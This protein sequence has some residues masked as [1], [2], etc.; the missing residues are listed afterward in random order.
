MCK[1]HRRL[2]KISVYENLFDLELYPDDTIVYN[3]SSLSGMDL[4]GQKDPKGLHQYFMS[5]NYHR[6][7][8]YLC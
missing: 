3:R 5:D 4:I 8:F 7:N 1:A 2:C 6:L